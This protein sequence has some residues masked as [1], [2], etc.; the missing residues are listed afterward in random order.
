[1]RTVPV[2]LDGLGG[3]GGHDAEVLS[4][5]VQQPA[6]GHDLVADL[7][8]AHGADLELPLPG[9]HLGVNATDDQAR[10]RPQHQASDLPNRRPRASAALGA[11]TT[12]KTT[13]RS[14]LLDTPGHM[15]LFPNPRPRSWRTPDF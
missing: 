5:A 6:G 11:F 12:L 10:L 7:L 9:H 1:M 2:T 3:E 13:S 4:E 14:P 8:R 15:H